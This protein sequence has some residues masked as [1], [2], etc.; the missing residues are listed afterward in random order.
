V[1]RSFEHEHLILDIFKVVVRNIIARYT[2]DGNFFV[3]VDVFALVNLGI[4]SLAYA[5]GKDVAAYLF[6]FITLTVF[7]YPNCEQPLAYF[8]IS[9]LIRSNTYL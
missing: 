3:R 7:Y 6:H 2:L 4:M 8:I 1:A 9:Q 5:L